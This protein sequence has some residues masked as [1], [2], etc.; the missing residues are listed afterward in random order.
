MQKY[1]DEFYTA[2]IESEFI[3]N[4]AQLMLGEEINSVDCSSNGV[5]I[6]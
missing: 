5:K 4:G 6:Q 2:I 3:A 1:F